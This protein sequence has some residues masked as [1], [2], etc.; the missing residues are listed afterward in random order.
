MHTRRL[1]ELL[2]A[3]SASVALVLLLSGVASI[4]GWSAVG[5][6][7]VPGL[8]AAA[9][10]FPQG[11]HSEWAYLYLV[12]GIAVDALLFTW[13]LVWYQRRSSKGYM[14]GSSF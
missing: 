12:L 9:V 10:L 8:L 11:G 1:R 13:P 6:L 3:F 4:P 5:V 14:P 7:L 2:F